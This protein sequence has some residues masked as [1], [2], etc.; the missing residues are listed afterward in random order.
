MSGDA[1]GLWDPEIMAM[2]VWKKSCRI[3]LV[4]LPD[5]SMLKPPSE[6]YASRQDLLEELK[7]RFPGTQNTNRK[8]STFCVISPEL[9]SYVGG[10]T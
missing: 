4:S 3:G 2:K 9:G 10:P 7:K 6:K 1:V 8:G 5:I